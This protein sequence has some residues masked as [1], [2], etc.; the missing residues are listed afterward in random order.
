M[1]CLAPKTAYQ[2]GL[3]AEA[4]AETLLRVKGYGILAR[5]FKTPQG[6][7]D[8]VAKRGGVLVFVEVKKRKTT[9]EAGE[10]IDARNQ[11]RVVTAA[12]LYL[13]AHPQYADMDMRFDAIV[14]ARSGLPQHIENAW[15][16][17]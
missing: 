12:T 6:E 14:F 16:A 1:T 2:T 8:I 13:Q 10:S 9:A 3:A 15:D 7:I 17:A 11:K 4:M 5:R